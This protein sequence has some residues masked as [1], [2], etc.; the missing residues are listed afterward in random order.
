[1]NAIPG[2]FVDHV[3]NANNLA[4]FADNTFTD[5]YASHVVEHL[6]YLEELTSTLKDW[7]RVLIPGGKVFISVPDLDVLAELFISKNKFSVAERFFVMRMIFGGHLDKYDYHIVGL[8]E[9]FLTR[10]LSDSGF[11]N[12]KRVKNF[13]LFDDTSAMIFKGVLVSLNL[14]A[15]KPNR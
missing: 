8:N 14:I 1:M 11:V 5:I 13:G 9:E 2:P 6:D 3:G 15:E 12:I 4:Q 7:N 10:Y